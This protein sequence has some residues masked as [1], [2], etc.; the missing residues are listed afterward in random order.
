VNSQVL[1]EGQSKISPTLRSDRYEY[2][3]W[4]R[5]RDTGDDLG[6]LEVLVR[7]DVAGGEG[8]VQSEAD[9]EEVD[10]PRHAGAR[11]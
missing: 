6:A 10:A 11:R 4:N 5:E 9:E 7:V 2:K 3:K 1:Y 8:K